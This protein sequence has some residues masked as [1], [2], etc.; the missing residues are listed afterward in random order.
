MRFLAVVIL[1]V[2]SLGVVGCGAPRGS[3]FNASL[4]QSLKPK[5]PVVPHFDLDMDSGEYRSLQR[6]VLRADERPD[7]MDDIVRFGARLLA[8]VEFLNGHRPSPL[9]LTSAESQVAYPIEEPRISNIAITE[10]IWTDLAGR[11]PTLMKS[12]VVD[13]AEFSELSGITDAEFILYAREINMV[14]QRAS[15]WLLQE[16]Y[17]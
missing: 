11:L 3:S 15:R 13:G 16:P 12:V 10:Q 6:T 14:Y 9:E 4:S 1:P 2:L 17:F 7:Q 5:M 8:W